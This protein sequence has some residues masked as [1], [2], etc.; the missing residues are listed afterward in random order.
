M[1]EKKQ[2]LEQEEKPAVYRF[3]RAFKR[4]AAFGMQVQFGRTVCPS[5]NIVV[6]HFEL[7]MPGYQLTADGPEIMDFEK[8]QLEDL[9][10]D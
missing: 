5:R 7:E 8:V 2:T 4:R 9:I 10:E 1:S 3:K 6:D